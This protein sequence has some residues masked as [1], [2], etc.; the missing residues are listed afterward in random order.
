MFAPF[1]IQRADHGRQQR[2]LGQLAQLLA[3]PQHALESRRVAPDGLHGLV[4][5]VALGIQRV[6]LVPAVDEKLPLRAVHLL[7]D[8]LGKGPLAQPL[9]PLR[10]LLLVD[11]RRPRG[12]DVAGQGVGL[13]QGLQ[14]AQQGRP[15]R[16][17]HL[18]HPVNEH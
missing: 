17:G 11:G 6:G 14:L 4:I 7:Q 15:L 12:D 8:D 16:L 2:R 5:A 9:A 13:Y 10:P 1:L 18:V 3:P